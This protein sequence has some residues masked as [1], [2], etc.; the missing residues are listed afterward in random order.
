ML[1]RAVAVE[2]PGRPAVAE[3][4][5]VRRE[6]VVWWAASRVVVF[7]GAFALHVTRVPH[8]YFGPAIFR[9]VF[10]PLEAWDGIW[11]RL[12]ATHGYLLVPGRQSANTQAV[13]AAVPEPK[14]SASPPSSSPSAC[15]ASAPVGCA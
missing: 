11:Y 10:G 2:T 9:P 15:S 5:A 13:I 6:I 14:R 3:W 7:A 1:E 12:I 4:L 8:G